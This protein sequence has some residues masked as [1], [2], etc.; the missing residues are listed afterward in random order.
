MEQ[1][2]GMTGLEIAIIGMAGR[3]PG[4][5]DL[6]QFWQNLADG[7]ECVSFFSEDELLSSGL[8]RDEIGRPEYVRARGILESPEEFDAGF[9][10]FT[11]REAEITDPQ[12]R[13]F[14]ECAWEVFEDAGY[15][16]DTFGGLIGV[17][18]GVG[19]ST[20]FFY[21]V[22]PALGS[23]FAFNDA[24]SVLSNEKDF[25]PTRVSYKLN[26]KGPSVAISTGCSSS[27]VA[28]HM[29]CKSLLAGEC[30]MALAGGVSIHFPVK[31]GY[32]F[33]EGGFASPDGHCR[34]FDIQ[35]Q[36]SVFGSGVGVVL[37]KRLEDALKD[38]DSI[39]ATIKGSATNNDGSRRVGFTAPSIEGQSEVIRLARLMAGVSPDSFTYIE[40]HGTAT[41][42]GDP[43]EVQALIEAS[44]APSVRKQ[45]CAIGSVKTNIG[46]TAEAA[47]V[48]GLIKTAL[49]LKHRKIPASLHFTKPNPKLNLENSPF[50][51]N[52]KLKDWV[53]HGSPLRAGVSS[54]GIG[55]SNAHVVLEEAPAVIA[56]RS[57]RNRSLLIIS[58]RSAPALE[59]YTDQLCTFL[60][61]NKHINL[62]DVA[63]TSQIGRKSFDYRRMMVCNDIDDAVQTLKTRDRQ[64]VCSNGRAPLEVP[65]IVMMFPGL[66]DDHAGMAADLYQTEPIFRA[67]LD[68]CF[69]LLQ[70]GMKVDFRDVLRVNTSSASANMGTAASRGGPDLRRMLG[71]DN[72]TGG[73]HVSNERDATWPRSHSLLPNLLWH[74]FG[75]TG[76]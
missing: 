12:Q 29:A 76:G 49:S 22:I 14:L 3:F 11:P 53:A 13:L 56:E 30:D 72:G 18:A 35:A 42:I 55:G 36:G 44:M 6:R 10:K 62:A 5:R 65:D 24:M 26:L 51:V 75:C 40:T 25:L 68:R 45:S 32:N 54:F 27:L 58:A 50:Y 52:D 7:R 38:R 43:I 64:R 2:N 9:F 33:A 39:Y 57:H 16:P 46:H 21:Q 37:L 17:F 61:E 66:G 23:G 69:Q 73:G 4:S 60:S 15:V 74:G 28:T 34:T 67:E 31:T 8:S 1:N 59:V 19:T 20:Y 71:R 41:P 70:Q 48:A 63:F 47:G